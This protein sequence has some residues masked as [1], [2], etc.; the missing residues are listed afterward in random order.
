MLIPTINRRFEWEHLAFP[1]EGQALKA[2]FQGAVNGR[3]SGTSGLWLLLT[4]HGVL[5][6]IPPQSL[7]GRKDS[8]KDGQCSGREEGDTLMGRSRP[9]L[10][11][12]IRFGSSSYQGICYNTVWNCL[13]QERGNNPDLFW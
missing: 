11:L 6:T 7:R 3:P 5:S 4:L 12:V 13:E 1:K 9:P 2:H 10:S 8:N